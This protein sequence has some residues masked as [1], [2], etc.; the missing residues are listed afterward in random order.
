M[1]MLLPCIPTEPNNTT[2]STTG[3]KTI[4]G[5]DCMKPEYGSSIPFKESLKEG[6]EEEYVRIKIVKACLKVSCGA[7]LYI[8]TL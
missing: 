2:C 6:V 1:D 8:K 4:Q 7:T 3:L 5:G